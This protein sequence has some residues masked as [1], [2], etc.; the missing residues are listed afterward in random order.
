MPTRRRTTTPQPTARRAPDASE[1]A[2]ARPDP[3]S[4]EVAGSIGATVSGPAQLPQDDASSLTDP[5]LQ[6]LAQQKALAQQSAQSMPHNAN[7]AA[8]HG[9]D[10]GRRPPEG[11]HE[12]PDDEIAP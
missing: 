11:V 12:E 6:R 4:D 2:A 5:S 1:G 7:K 10:A 3:A 8:E 9:L